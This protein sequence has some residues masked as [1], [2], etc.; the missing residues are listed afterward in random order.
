M[1]MSKRRVLSLGWIL[2]SSLLAPK[3]SLFAPTAQPLARVEASPPIYEFASTNEWLTLKDGV[4]LSVTF[5]RPARRSQGEKF[6]V[7]L[8]YL[9]YR[10]D[11]GGGGRVPPY[12]YFAKRGFIVAK[13]DIRGTGSSEGVF[14]GRE[15]TEQELDDAVDI[16]DQ[17]SKLPGSNGRVGMFGISWGGF[18]S[19]QV[20]MR[21][22]PALK[23]IL[24]TDATDDLYHDD[25]HFIDGVLHI[26][27]WSSD[28]YSSVA[29]PQ[30]PD[31]PVNENYF[32]DR[33]DQ[34]PGFI[35]Y[36]KQQRDGEFWRKNSLRWQYDKIRI[37]TYL[38]GG[39]LDGYKD[40]VPRMLESMKV[41]VR[42][43]VGPWNHAY[44]DY[45]VPG[46]NY[47][48][49]HEAVRWWDFWLKD[50]NTGIQEDS[51]LT[52]FIREGQAPDARLKMTPGHWVCTDWP[53]PGTKW[54][55]SS[56]EKTISCVRCRRAKVRKAPL[57]P[58]LRQWPPRASPGILRSCGGEIPRETC[59]LTMQ[60]VL[61]MTARCSK[62]HLRSLD[63]PR[64]IFVFP[65][66]LQSAHW[67]ARLED[68]QP[69]GTVSLV[70]G[71]NINGSQRESRL[72][73]KPL[74]PGEAFDVDFEMH[75]TTW[76]FKPGHRV[77]LAI[78][79]AAFPM[80]WPTPYPMV[81]DTLYGR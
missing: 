75:F 1:Q 42:A 65:P 44:P 76:T 26:D 13:V 3:T 66:M 8:E 27:S 81:T 79:N 29:L 15:Y 74:V 5:Y 47:E 45:G 17:L 18:N 35:T 10:K 12:P 49:K 43:A 31:W 16:I 41:P 64:S 51:P 32:R 48:W 6:P 2:F 56:L 37:P 28:F 30:T 21:Q 39:L 14:P 20:A 40:S 67:V 53:V 60:E 52:V 46:P 25:I 57:C 24:A 54:K 77:R 62:K 7:L 33:F 73:P 72:N 36:L 19:I 22:P 80:I 61:S 68:V 58:E 38:I 59:V 71:S 11:D 9:P 63:F 69:D 70:T 4:R 78:S 55:I 50:R 23:A 34:Y